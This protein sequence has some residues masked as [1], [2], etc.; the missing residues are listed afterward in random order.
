VQAA[1]PLHPPTSFGDLLRQARVKGSSSTTPSDSRRQSVQEV[2]LDGQADAEAAIENQKNQRESRKRV[3][4]ADV[5][6]ERRRAKARE[7]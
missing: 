3:R 7:E 5:D 4:P 6:K 1:I 2:R